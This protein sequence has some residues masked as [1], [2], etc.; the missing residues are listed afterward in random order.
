M[1]ADV[2]KHRRLPRARR[3][4]AP[5][6]LLLALRVDRL[7][8][9]VLDVSAVHRHD[10]AEFARCHHFARLPR[11]GVTGVVQCDEEAALLGFRQRHQRLSFGKRRR[12]RLVA[13]DVDAGFQKS[14]GDRRTQMGGRDDDHRLD[15]VRPRR[16]GLCHRMVVS[17]AALRRDADLGGRCRG[18]FG[19]RRQRTRHQRDLVVE[20]YGQPMNRADEGVAAA[21]NHADRQAFA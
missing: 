16:F 4:G 9:P 2:G 20:P 18:V 15:A 6:G 7:R 11:H 10:A 12:Q 14:S 8:Q 13:D 3:V 5:F 1:H 21:S 19:I 17:I